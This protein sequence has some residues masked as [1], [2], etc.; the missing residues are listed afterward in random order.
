[1]RSLPYERKESL[2]VYVYIPLSLLGNTSVKTFTRQRIQTTVEQLLCASFSVR[3]LPYERK[4][5]LWVYVY[6]PLSLLG[7]SSVKTFPRQRIETT[8]KELLGA[9]FSVRSLPYERKESLWVYVYIPLSLSGNS[10]VKTF[11]RQ[12]RIVV[13]VVFYAVRVVSKESSRLVLPRT[14][15]LNSAI[16]SVVCHYGS[17]RR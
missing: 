12:R 9:S 1:V 6:I 16:K 3:S 17:C 8:A 14:S 11:P 13:G 7:N 10:S 4:E 15:C 2:W 5:S